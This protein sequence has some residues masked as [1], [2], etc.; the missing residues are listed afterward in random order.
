MYTKILES[1]RWRNSDTMTWCSLYQKWSWGM[2]S[3]SDNSSYITGMITLSTLRYSITTEALL[4][5][6]YRWLT[7][8]PYW[9]NTWQNQLKNMLIRH[10]YGLPSGHTPLQDLLQHTGIPWY[11]TGDMLSVM[12]VLQMTEKQGKVNK[13]TWFFTTVDLL[14]GKATDNER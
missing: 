11:E 2:D 10:T 9:R 14:Y 5:Y 13:D 6:S 3:S 12:S 7:I 8:S 1:T 4:E